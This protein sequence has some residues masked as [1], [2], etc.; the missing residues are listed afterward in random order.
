MRKKWW[1]LIGNLTLLSHGSA[2][3]IRSGCIA[4]LYLNLMPWI[5]VSLWSALNPLAMT[6]EARDILSR[7][8]GNSVT[9]LKSWQASPSRPS[10]RSVMTI[11][12]SK[13]WKGVTWSKLSPLFY[14]PNYRL[15][16]Y[17]SQQI[18]RVCMIRIKR[19]NDVREI[20]FYYSENS[21]RN[22]IVWQDAE[23]VNVKVY[24]VSK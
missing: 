3:H 7:K 4:Y 20:I 5:T 6:G 9:F 22:F 14:L 13:F 2:L 23:F 12:T 11:E 1:N 15:S 19:L 18:L 16:A 17:T 24:R 10:E 21:I 8:G